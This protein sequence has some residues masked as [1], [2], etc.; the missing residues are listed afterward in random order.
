MTLWVTS[1]SSV[2]HPDQ[3]NSPTPAQVE[4]ARN[5]RR[6]EPPALDFTE[7]GFGVPAVL[8]C[9]W[10]SKGVTVFFG[11]IDESDASGY[12]TPSSDSTCSSA[13]I[14]GLRRW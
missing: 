6:P 11:G 2:P 10:P 13:A 3:P 14:S 7:L 1:P 5:A 4:A 8:V 12:D 9:P